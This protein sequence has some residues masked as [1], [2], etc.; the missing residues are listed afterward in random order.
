[1]KRLTRDEVRYGRGSGSRP[2]AAVSKCRSCGEEFAGGQSMSPNTFAD[3]I[4]VVEATKG[5][6]VEY[7]AA[8]T[9][10]DAA[11]SEVQQMLDSGW[12]AKRITARHLPPDQIA[13]LKIKAGS[14]RKLK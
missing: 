13:E 4:Y 8:A 10:R 6:E 7:W 14:V 11:L 3:G 2:Q 12:T 1:M 5:R 9:P